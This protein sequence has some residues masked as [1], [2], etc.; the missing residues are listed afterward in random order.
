[1]KAAVA[2]TLT[3]GLPGALASAILKPRIIGPDQPTDRFKFVVSIQNS[4]K[5]HACGGMLL[6]STTVLTASHCFLNTTDAGFVVAGKTDLEETGG[7]TVKISTLQRP[8]HKAVNYKVAHTKNRMG[9]IGIIKLATPIE[10]SDD[11]DYAPLPT[12]DAVPDGS[13]ELV[14]LG[15][16]R[17]TTW[18][19]GQPAFSV[20]K[21]AEAQLEQ[22]PF[23][24]CLNPDFAGDV[25]TLICAGKPG[26]TVC[27]GDSGGPLIDSKT[28][29]LVGLVSISIAN[30]QGV[31]CSDAGIFTRVGSYLDFINENL[32]QRG[33]T[34]GDN[35]RIKDEAKRPA[36]LKSCKKK[37]FDN[38]KTCR[39][40]ANDAFTS[41]GNQQATKEEWAAY[42][43]DIANC[44]AFKNMESACDGCAEK[45]TVDSTDET[46][47]QCSEA[48]KKG[49]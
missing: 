24:K 8:L 2:I 1:M 13:E 35:Q 23:S 21:R 45:A 14:A 42:R 33:F 41:N 19:Q 16:G 6:D 37:H 25:S 49:N 15:W 47:I 36:L 38:F 17:N 46:V 31:G 18:S 30:P 4:T 44:D 28:G 48:V 26:K 39:Q 40:N 43:Q 20:P 22:Q 5:V 27:S 11:I 3:A 32:G 29:T 12:S 10:K 9:D 34:D 7:V